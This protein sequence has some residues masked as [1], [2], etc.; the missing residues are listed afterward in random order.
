MEEFQTYFEQTLE[1]H[2]RHETCVDTIANRAPQ[3][4]S[5]K[6]VEIKVTNVSAWRWVIRCGNYWKRG[7][8]DFQLRKVKANSL[9]KNA[10]HKGLNDAQPCSL[11]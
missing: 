10:Y 11:L 9:R 4:Y 7:K 2:I 6:V 8:R 5:A 1:P 3:P